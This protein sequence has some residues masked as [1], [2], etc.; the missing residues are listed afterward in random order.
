MDHK[1]ALCLDI[2]S[3]ES[4]SSSQPPDRSILMI[5]AISAAQ[6]WMQVAYSMEYA[7][8]NPLIGKLGMPQWSY[9]LVT[10]SDPLTGL[11]VQP[12]FGSLSDRCR[13]KW[14]RRR[15]FI[16]FGSVLVAVF[17]LFQLFTE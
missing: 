10:A 8:S 11:F 12:I 17:L 7:L 1:K 6:R 3:D 13:S 2:L 16:L 5:I 9:A 4:P 15:P 14:G